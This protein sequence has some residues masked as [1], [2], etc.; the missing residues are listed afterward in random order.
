MTHSAAQSAGE[1]GKHTQIPMR[2]AGAP[3][4]HDDL[5]GWARVTLAQMRER[6]LHGLLSLKQEEPEHGIADHAGDEADQ[7]ASRSEHET[8]MRA[9]SVLSAQLLEIDAAIRRTQSGEYGICETT[10]RE[11]PVAR[12]RPNPLAR[13]TVEAQEQIERT[14]RMYAKAAT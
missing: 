10:G 6:T 9:A 11:I 2:D 12:L 4:P 5:M 13:Y 1:A 14:A 8:R 7:S 3:D